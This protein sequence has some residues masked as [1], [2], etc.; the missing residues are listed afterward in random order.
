MALILLTATVALGI[1][2]VSRL[3]SPRWPRVITAGLHRNISLLVVAFVIVHVLTTVLDTYVS[4]S[5]AAL[6]IPFVSSYRPVWLSLGTLA[7]DMI[8]AVIITSLFRARLSYRAWGTVHMLAY[9]SWPVALWHGLGTGTDSKLPWVLALDALCVLVVAGAL[10][11][12][13]QR[14][15]PGA[16]R[17]AAMAAT[18]AVP[19][20]T[21]AFVVAGPLQTGWAAQ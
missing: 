10:L 13:L 1:T 2:G 19:V 16:G 14:M 12:R 20:A 4:I 21:I 17:V 15:A 18:V 5:P 7:F 9:V 8:L 11:V 3:S 6:V